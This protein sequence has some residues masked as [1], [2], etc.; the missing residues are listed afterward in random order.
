MA[1]AHPSAVDLSGSYNG[2]YA[3]AGDGYTGGSYA[4]GEEGDRYFGGYAELL[5]LSE[6][7]EGSLRTLRAAANTRMG[8]AFAAT[9]GEVAA[10]VAAA[11]AVLCA[12]DAKAG[13]EAVTGVRLLASGLLCPPGLFESPGLQHGGATRLSGPAQSEQPGGNG[14]A[15]QSGWCVGVWLWHGAP[16]LLCFSGSPSQQSGR[17]GLESGTLAPSGKVTLA[18]AGV[19]LPLAAAGGGVTKSGTDSVSDHGTDPVTGSVM[20]SVTGSTAEIVS[21]VTFDVT[22][23]EWARSLPA[24]P[25]AGASLGFALKVSSVLGGAPFELSVA[26][27]AVRDAL[28][29]CLERLRDYSRVSGHPLALAGQILLPRRPRP[30]RHAGVLELFVGAESHRES[31]IEMTGE[32]AGE[33]GDSRTQSRGWV[34]VFAALGSETLLLLRAGQGVVLGPVQQLLALGDSSRISQLDIRTLSLSPSPHLPPIFLRAPT[35]A[36]AARW[37]SELSARQNAVLG[38]GQSTP[39]QTALSPALPEAHSARVQPPST[40]AGVRLLLQRAGAPEPISVRL[41]RPLGEVALLPLAEAQANFPAWQAWTDG[42]AT[43]LEPVVPEPLVGAAVS[44]S[45]FFASEHAW[46]WA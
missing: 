31:E 16:A 30:L 18:L 27:A 6:G 46:A 23:I 39:E 3:E 1:S 11:V 2:S 9:D 15:G 12:P 22:D 29:I 42:V 20:G 13:F 36:A 32:L 10:R 25:A 41:A 28:C 7:A 26:S 34:R 17:P 19:L 40:V 33:S 4:G 24:G 37:S 38:N 8:A 35:A 44:V 5:G 45:A 21:S 14:Q 43:A